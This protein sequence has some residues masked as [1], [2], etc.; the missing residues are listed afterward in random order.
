MK[1]CSLIFLAGLLFLTAAAAQQSPKKPGKAA[2]ATSKMGNDECLACH[3]DAT[4]TKEEN[5]K[6]ISLHVD[7]AKFKGSIHS[8]TGWGCPVLTC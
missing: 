4:L 6:T 7:D 3:N 8:V 5:G 2:A 1:R